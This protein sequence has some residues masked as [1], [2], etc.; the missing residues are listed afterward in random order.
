MP[1]AIENILKNLASELYKRAQ[2]HAFD[3]SF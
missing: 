3:N 2:D 1:E